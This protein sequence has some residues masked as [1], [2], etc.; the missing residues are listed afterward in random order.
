MPRGA[1]Y[2]QEEEK[3]AGAKKKAFHDLIETRSFMSKKES[4]ECFCV[5]CSSPRKLRYTRYLQPRHYFQIIVLTIGITAVSF[6]WLALN[7]AFSLPVVWALFES[8]HKSLYR[9]DL[10]CSICGFDPK[11]YKKDVKL[12]RRKVEEFLKQ[13]PESPV[14]KRARKIEETTQLPL[15]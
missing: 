2:G 5:L 3:L 14:L 11:W 6:P 10:K 15:N 13:N 9:K 12:A 7:G 4:S 8:I 1:S